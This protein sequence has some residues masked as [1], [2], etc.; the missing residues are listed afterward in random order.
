MIK[1]EKRTKMMISNLCSKIAQ[2]A[3]VSSEQEEVFEY[4]VKCFVEKAVVFITIL[5]YGYLRNDVLQVLVFYIICML[6]RKHSGGLHMNTFYKCYIG[7]VLLVIGMT[8]LNNMFNI[9]GCFWLV[10]IINLICAV[11]VMVIGCV[12]NP[13]LDL[14]TEELKYNKEQTRQ[15]ILIIEF[16]IMISYILTVKKIYIAL[17]CEAVICCAVLLV[18]AKLTGQEI[19]E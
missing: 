15:T 17:C 7:S 1:K 3:E 2:F 11:I 19:K 16:I 14:T 9:K 4:I 8:E 12:N 18:I 5:L 13:E 10:F 6:I